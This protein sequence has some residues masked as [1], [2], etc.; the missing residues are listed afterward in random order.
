MGALSFCMVTTFYPPYH[1]GGEAMYLYCLSNELAR[2]GHRVTVVHCVDSYRVQTSAPP[3][4]DFPHEPGVTV[5]RLASRVGRVS[6][7]VT[8]LSGRPGL[9]SKAL[10]R[11]FADERFDVVHFHLMTLFGPAALRYGGDALRLYTMHD[12]WLVCPMY[13]LW[14]ENREL[15]EKPEC[16]RCQ[17][18]FRRP[19]QLWRYTDLL[20]DALPEID[21]FFAPSRSTIEQHHRRGF[22]YPIQHL[23]YFLPSRNGAD[24]SPSAG[25][26]PEV[27][28]P[29]FLF[30]G[31]LVRLKGV[32]TL[33]DVFRRYTAAD[34][35][36][37]G[38]GVLE[39]ELR[40]QAGDLEHVHFLGRVPPARLRALYAG[41]IAVLV[42]ALAYET[43]GLIAL[44]AL[45]SGTPVI[46]R[47]LGAVAEVVRESEGGLLY[48]SDDE[49]VSLMEELRTDTTRRDE[50]G[51]RGHEVASER[52]SEE[53]HLD[54]YLTAIEQARAARTAEVPSARDG[55][56][57]R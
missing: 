33:I 52:W 29:Y 15:C 9:K 17:L 6:P 45:A 13:D 37:A 40:R 56:R 41:A 44:E 2:R 3:R 47:D 20:D 12:H 51:L 19:P 54:T 21:V 16:L 50:L 36:I 1:S 39:D 7:L 23:P 49:L 10:D 22:R 57:P 18:S 35:V 55:V 30:A 53:A 34:L 25:G 8:Y 32:H 5:H 28:R 11:I 43:F 27:S 4:G 31:R 14:K 26:A 38:D 46:A 42:P 48:T 24:Q